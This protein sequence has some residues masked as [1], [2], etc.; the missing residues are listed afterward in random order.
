VKWGN[1]LN[2]CTGENSSEVSSNAPQDMGM[3]SKETKKTGKKGR[4]EAVGRDSVGF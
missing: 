4:V 2:R 3:H 1:L